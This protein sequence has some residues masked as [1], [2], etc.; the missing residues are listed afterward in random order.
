MTLS[1]EPIGV[2]TT[3]NGKQTKYRHASKQSALIFSFFFA[4]SAMSA[5]PI[6]LIYQSSAESAAKRRA[7]SISA[8]PCPTLLNA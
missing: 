4:G 1:S 5:P 3:V 6:A 2:V 8:C 7:L